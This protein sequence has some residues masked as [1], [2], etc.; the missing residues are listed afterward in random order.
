M[1]DLFEDGYVD[2]A[3]FQPTYLTDFYVHGFNTTEQDG[4]WPR[5]IRT[6]SSS[7][8]LRTR[9]RRGRARQA[10]RLAERWQLKGVKLYTAEWRGD[11]KGW[12]LSDPWAYRYL[13]K[14]AGARHQEHPRA[15]G[16][17]HLPAEPGRVRRRRRGRRGLAF[18]DL[19]FI[20]EHVGLPRLEDF[21]WIA[22]QEP[23]VYGGL[24]VAMPFIHTRP[25]YLAQIIG[26][27]LL[28]DRRRPDHVRERLRDLDAAVAD[29]GLRRLRDPGGHDRRV[30]ADS[31]PTSRR[32]SSA[33]TR[34]GSTTSRCRSSAGCRR[35]PCPGDRGADRVG[36]RC[37]AGC[38]RRADDCPAGRRSIA[39][40]ASRRSTRCGTQSSTSPSPTLP[41][42]Q[43][44]QRRRRRTSSGRPAAADVLLRTELRLPD[45]GGR[46][47]RGGRDRRASSG[48]DPAAR[49]L[50]LRG[51]QRRGQRGRRLPRALP[52]DWRTT[53]WPSCGRCSGPRR[54][55]RAQERVAAATAACRVERRSRLAGGPDARR[56]RRLAAPGPAAPSATR[57]RTA[58]R[59]SRR[60]RCSTMRGRPIRRP[61]CRYRCAS[62]GRRGSASR[63]TPASAAACSAS[64]T[65]VR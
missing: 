51:D 29:R 63:A 33:S 21:C 24:A 32:R 4:A 45:G 47:R 40:R 1:H 22:T 53:S 49:S 39:S 16:P 28:L 65:A 10:R 17:D 50:R 2:V 14:C 62:R 6:A 19:N 57:P 54:T 30:R 23:N 60:R 48:D 36:R 64:A 20:V 55:P 3:I 43:D 15:Q 9:G 35:M 11:S 34:P 46:L 37:R 31:P 44:V 38:R 8:G 12:K 26:E 42:S 41:S 52:R 5:S 61:T 25:R 13:E 56:C 27:L 7:T 59:R 58:A 18:S